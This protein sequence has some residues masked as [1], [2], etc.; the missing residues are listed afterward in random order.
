MEDR[1][2]LLNQVRRQGSTHE[3]PA[4]KGP[5]YCAMEDGKSGN[6]CWCM[7]IKAVNLAETD[8]CLCKVCLKAEVE[9]TASV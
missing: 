5:A 9:V 2:R 8:Q 4:C 7:D 1:A 6:L 3:C